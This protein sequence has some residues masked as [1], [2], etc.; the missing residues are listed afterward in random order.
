[1][2]PIAVHHMLCQRVSQRSEQTRRLT[3]DIS[4]GRVAEVEIVSRIN[5]NLSMQWQMIAVYRLQH[6]R[7]Q[8]GT[9]AWVIVS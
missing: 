2:D 1:M 3:H 9:G 5:L 7:E 8:T 4:Q 6:M